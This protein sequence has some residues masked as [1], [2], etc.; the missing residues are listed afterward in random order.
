[1]INIYKVDN[2]SSI[3]D[4]YDLAPTRYFASIEE[5]VEYAGSITLSINQFPNF[6]HDTEYTGVTVYSVELGAEGRQVS[7]WERYL[8]WNPDSGKLPPI[9]LYFQTQTMK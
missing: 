3:Q 5:A 1:M 9:G 2:Y 6:L 8:E 7:V 4:D